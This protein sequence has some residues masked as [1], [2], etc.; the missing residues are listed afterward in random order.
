M[1]H[2]A[3]FDHNQTVAPAISRWKTKT[4]S[5]CNRHPWRLFEFFSALRLAGGQHGTDTRSGDLAGLD[6]IDDFGP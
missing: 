2:I 1:I 5:L 6:G 4:D 3:V